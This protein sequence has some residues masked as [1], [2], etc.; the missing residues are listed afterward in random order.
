LPRASSAEE[1]KL[2]DKPKQYEIPYRLTDTKHVLVRVKINDKGPFNLILDTGAPAL[3]LPKPIAKKA[4]LDVDDK[5]WGAIKK[6]EFEG[7]LAVDQVRAHVTDIFQVEG[8]NGLGV[9]GVELHGMIGYEVLARFR[10][11]Y[12]F[13]S[14]KLLFEP[15]VGFTPPPPEKV[16]VKGGDDIQTMGPLVKMISAFLGIK[17]NFDRVPRGFVGIE[18]DDADGSLVIKKV[19][20]GS[21]AEEAGFKTGDT[22]QEIKAITVKTDKD[23][24]KALAK[25][26]VGSKLL[27]TLKR[28]EKTEEVTIELGKGL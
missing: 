4:G 6:F 28:G 25:A 10:I 22:I 21:P 3:F 17:P 5:G 1:P 2:A 24:T 12:D 20:P 23:L 27:F 16:D 26:G 9:A 15:L 14:D 19:L 7:G 11:Q 8:M 18:F 13:R